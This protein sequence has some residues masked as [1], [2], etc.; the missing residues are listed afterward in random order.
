MSPAK[1][2]PGKRACF[3]DRVIRIGDREIMDPGDEARGGEIVGGLP[4]HGRKREIERHRGD[5]MGE[6]DI[7]SGEP[8]FKK[9]P[10]R[11]APTLK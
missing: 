11:F 10:E 9:G 7:K 3:G 4:E 6:D 8:R 2:I 1:E 5:V